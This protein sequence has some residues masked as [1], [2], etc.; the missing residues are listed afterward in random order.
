LANAYTDKRVDAVQ[1]SVDEL[2]NE[3]RSVPAKSSFG[4]Q[5]VSYSK[6]LQDFGVIDDDG[7]EVIDGTD[8]I[9]ALTSA[10]NNLPAPVDHS[11]DIKALTDVVSAL[12]RKSQSAPVAAA[13]SA[14]PPA[15]YSAPQ[16]PTY[17]SAPPVSYQSS[18]TTYAS[19][20]KTYGSA[21]PGGYKTVRKTRRVA[22]TVYEEVPY[23]EQVAV[24][25]RDVYQTVQEQVPVSVTK[26]RMRT[27]QRTRKVPKT[28]LVD[29][30]Y[31]VNVPE[32]YSETVMQTRS[33]RVKVGT[34][35]VAVAAAPVAVAAAPVRCEPAPVAVAAAPVRC[36]PTVSFSAA[37]TPEPVV[38]SAPPSYAAEPCVECTPAVER[39]VSYSVA[40]S[41]SYS[42]A[43]AAFS[44]IPVLS[45]KYSAP[46]SAAPRAA[47]PP[48]FYNV[49]KP[50]SSPVVKSPQ[51]FSTFSAPPTFRSASPAVESQLMMSTP[52]VSTPA[53]A[54]RL[55]PFA[56]AAKS[57]SQVRTQNKANGGGLFQ[58]GKPQTCVNGTCARP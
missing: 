55:R 8:E 3:V 58:S 11:A 41:V 56:T 5:S 49:A 42:V 22:K 50:V 33:K 6:P 26:T 15:T 28:I 16:A 48:M 35:Q 20:P 46:R 39:S 51:S 47:A 7:V 1:Q 34:E 40:P 24:A 12:A 30:A 52:V 18:P 45:N 32:Q 25:V 31:S 2:R 19:G 29:E 36:E 4:I 14:A 10:V 53:R 57:Y 27:E 21:R 38:Y 17:A 23:E 37:P 13:Y 43:P 54:Q 9:K 44:A